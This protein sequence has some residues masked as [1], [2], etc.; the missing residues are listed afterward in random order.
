MR[1]ASCLMETMLL[2]DVVDVD[3]VVAAAVDDDN[4]DEGF[5]CNCFEKL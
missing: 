5:Q 2:L 1:K 4:V 3:F